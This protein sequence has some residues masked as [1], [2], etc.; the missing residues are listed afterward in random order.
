MEPGSSAYQWYDHLHETI[1]TDMGRLEQACV[2][3]FA[4]KPHSRWACVSEV[5]SMT[6]GYMQPVVDFMQTIRYKAKEAT[7]SEIQIVDAIIGGLKQEIRLSVIPKAPKDLDELIKAAE[8]AEVSLV[9]GSKNASTEDTSN[10]TLVLNK[11][12][13]LAT[14]VKSI[15]TE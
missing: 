5:N 11:I 9:G 13:S 12:E 15:R 4:L 14:D 8:L 6:Q 1:K 7:M 3:R 10:L 2:E